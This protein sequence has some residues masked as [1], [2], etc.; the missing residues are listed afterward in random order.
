MRRPISWKSNSCGV[1]RRISARRSPGC[2]A[3]TRA[4]EAFTTSSGRGWVTGAV[5][6]ATVC[7][8]AIREQ[9]TIEPENTAIAREIGRILERG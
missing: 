7:A 4:K 5:M 6:P 8:E 3:S 1:T 2:T 9:H